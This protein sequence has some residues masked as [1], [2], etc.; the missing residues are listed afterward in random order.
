MYYACKFVFIWICMYIC[1]Y[2][3]MYLCMYVCLVE[4]ITCADVC[5]GVCRTCTY[6]CVHVCVHVRMIICVP[7]RMNACIHEFVHVRNN[8]HV[9]M[10][11][12]F[13]YDLITVIYNCKLNVWQDWHGERET[14]GVDWATGDGVQ[15]SVRA[16]VISWSC[17]ACLRVCITSWMK[18]T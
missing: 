11:V 13:Y 2:T 7:V 1:M 4:C 5:A 15:F 12:C 6:V 8:V 17:I 16:A 18:S 14:H 10:L 3:C 9:C